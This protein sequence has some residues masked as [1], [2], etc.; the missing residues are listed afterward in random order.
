MRL[1]PD[2]RSAATDQDGLLRLVRACLQR[3]ELPPVPSDLGYPGFAAAAHCAQR[4]H[5][6]GPTDPNER[7]R[8]VA[9]LRTMPRRAAAST[10]RA[11]RLPGGWNAD[12]APPEPHLDESLA[13]ALRQIPERND[14]RAVTVHLTDWNDEQRDTVRAAAD[15]L[16]SL[17]PDMLAEMAVSVRQVAVLAGWGIDG[18][19]DFAAHGAIFVN[20]R[21]L[22]ADAGGPPPRLR[23]AEAL[24]HEGAHTRCNTAALAAPFLTPDGPASEALVATPLRADPRPLSGLFQQ[25]VVLARCVMLYDL[26][27]RDDPSP[28]PEIPARRDLLL[29]QGRKG[30]AVAQAHRAQLTRA[31]RDVLDEAAEVIGRA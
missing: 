29:S 23:L 28:V 8:L 15:L 27:L 19:T 25:V 20:E 21:R 14:G 17:W 16:A 4:L 11:V 5:R 22:A 1:L 10:H 24:V 3:P 6:P 30:V 13:R 9:E 7:E 26:V 31:G 12:L 18:F 2:H